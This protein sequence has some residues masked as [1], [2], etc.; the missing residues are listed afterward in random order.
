[1]ISTKWLR[2][3]QPYLESEAPYKVWGAPPGSA[4][5]W[6]GGHAIYWEI[7]AVKLD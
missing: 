7:Y 5:N 1:M 6:L 3:S 4:T 2:V